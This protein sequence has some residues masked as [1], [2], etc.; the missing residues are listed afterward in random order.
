MY[1]AAGQ[2]PGLCHGLIVSRAQPNDV[3]T[4]MPLL[5]SQR[6]SVV[7]GVRNSFEAFSQAIAIKVLPV[8]TGPRTLGTKHMGQRLVSA[9]PSR[10]QN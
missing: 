4:V 3:T 9:F 8:L 10:L 2:F 7:S 5:A 6:L 1:A